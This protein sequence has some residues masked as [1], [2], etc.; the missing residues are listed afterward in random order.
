MFHSNLLHQCEPV[1]AIELKR[2]DLL[3]IPR[4]VK[5]FGGGEGRRCSQTF[6][7]NFIDDSSN[8]LSR[9]L[10][11]RH[12]EASLSRSGNDKFSL[13]ISHL[14]RY[15]EDEFV[16]VFTILKSKPKISKKLHKVMVQELY[17]SM[18]GDLEAMLE[19]EGAVQD[20]L[21]K[22]AELSE[23]TASANEDA[24]LVDKFIGKWPLRGYSMNVPLI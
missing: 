15:S 1:Q 5:I 12:G 11:I 20:A 3:Y 22:I 8:V 23:D 6:L 21:T 16:R 2:T 18:N 24:W 4:Y 19:D 9:E 13:P 7:T 14:F 10:L 17:S